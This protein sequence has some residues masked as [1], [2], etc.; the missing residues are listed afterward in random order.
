MRVD[1]EQLRQ[2]LERVGFVLGSVARVLERKKQLPPWEPAD[3]AQQ[4]VDP[5]PPPVFNDCR[6]APSQPKPSVSKT[7][8][9]AALRQT[10]DL[11]D[12]I[13]GRIE[14]A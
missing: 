10:R 13:I 7:D 2:D 9:V 5:P 3:F 14:K 12:D 11:L 1:L 6:A 4:P 8:L